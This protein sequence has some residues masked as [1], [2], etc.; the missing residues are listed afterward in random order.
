[1][2]RQNQ[3]PIKF[4]ELLKEESYKNGSEKLED[5]QANI[6]FEDVR[7]AYNDEEYVLEDINLE[8]KKNQSVAFVGHTGSGKSTIMNLIYGFYRVNKGRS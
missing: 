2:K 6:I 1:M 3:R 8:V 5:L 4:S 7:F